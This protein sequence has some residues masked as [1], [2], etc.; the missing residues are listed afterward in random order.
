MG[1][2][3]DAVHPGVEPPALGELVGVVL[4]FARSG[5][6]GGEVGAGFRPG[7]AA[8][9]SLLPVAGGEREEEQSADGSPS[10]KGRG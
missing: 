1:V 3:A 8:D 10:L 6:A 7:L 5:V 4:I 9:G 2:A